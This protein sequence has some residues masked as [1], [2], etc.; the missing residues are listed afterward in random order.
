LQLTEVSAF[1]GDPAEILIDVSRHLDLLVSAVLSSATEPR[2]LSP[3]TAGPASTAPGN[4]FVFDA[5]RTPERDIVADRRLELHH[6][7]ADG[8]RAPR[9]LDTV[10]GAAGRSRPPGDRRAVRRV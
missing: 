10:H 4:E 2:S 6:V 1:V 9:R 5:F 7:G 3:R 8:H